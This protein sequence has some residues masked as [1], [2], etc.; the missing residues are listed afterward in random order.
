MSKTLK[1]NRLFLGLLLWVMG[2]SLLL[3]RVN[4]N[5]SIWTNMVLGEVIFLIP[6]LVFLMSLRAPVKEWMPSKRMKT[7][8]FWMSML[9]A[10]LLLPLTSFLNAL[11]M[12]FAQN[13]V[14]ADST[15]LAEGSVWLNLAVVALV[16]AAAEEFLFRGVFYNG[17]RENGILKAALAGGLVFGLMHRNLNQFFYAAVLGF[18]FCLLYEASGSIKASMIAHFTVNAWNVLLIALQ[19]PALRYLEQ[20]MG[21]EY[22][23]SAQTVTQQDLVNYI[24]SAGILAVI[25]TPLAVC[26]LIWIA[27]RNGRFRQVF[28]HL[29]WERDESGERQIFTPSFALAV[30]ICIGYMVMQEL[31]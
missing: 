3:T 9:F 15:Y 30:G 11:S 5:V 17:Y 18:C 23:R 21:S 25:C 28:E 13:Y 12:L 29:G 22:A 16:P 14:S 26:A 4:L 10:G 6:A 20:T 2:L 19:E 27:K 24:C 7:G 8:T 31:I 1:T